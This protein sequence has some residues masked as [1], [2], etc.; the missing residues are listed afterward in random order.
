MNNTLGLVFFPAFDWMIS[1]N[2]PERKERLLYTRDQLTE[3]GIF[4]LR[5]IKEFKPSIAQ[6]RDI[7]RVHIGPRLNQLITQAHLVS[8]GGCITAAEA[9]MSKQVERAFSLV[10]PPGHHAMRLVQGI[11]GFCTINIEAVMIEYLRQHYGI[12]KVAIVDTDVHHGDGTQEIYYNDPD[13]L[14]ISFHQDGRTLYPGSGFIEELGTPYGYGS[15]INLPLL[16]ETGDAGIHL[17]FD[18]LIRPILDDFQPDI[19]INS[20]GQDNHFSDPL[21]SMSFTAQGYARLADKLKAD[22]AVLEGGY[23]I[24]KALPY[25]NTGIILAMANM[26]YSKVVEPQSP[27]SL[28]QPENCTRHI[29]RL[30]NE[31]GEIWSSRQTIRNNMLQACGGIYTKNKHIYYDES[32]ISENQQ[33]INYYCD[34]CAGYSTIVSKACGL[35]SFVAL[36]PINCCPKCC[37][38]AYDSAHAANKSSKYTHI[39][40][41]DRIQDTLLNYRS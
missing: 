32:G 8:A 26:D 14:F 9:V 20:A 10:R 15:T 27:T 19:I 5:Q 33:E 16:P 41:Q 24:Q 40:I 23:S 4:D 2:H 12:K 35:T 39:F 28:V 36:M 17:L 25:I 7:E 30:I 22:I 1:P 37:R 18:K 34:E 3:E 13:T 31:V 11:R 38:K 29:H 21:A 6:M